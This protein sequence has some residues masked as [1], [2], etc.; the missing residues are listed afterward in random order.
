M[1]HKQVFFRSEARERILRGVTARRGPG[2]PRPQIQ[3]RPA[4][5]A[6]W[7]AGGLQ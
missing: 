2:H 7:S 3:V 6:L 4:R 1:A 5:K